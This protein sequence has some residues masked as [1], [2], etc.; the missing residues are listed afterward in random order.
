[1]LQKSSQST[2]G[3]H[4]EI[5]PGMSPKILSKSLFED[6]FRRIDRDFTEIFS[7]IFP[8]TIFGTRTGPWIY[9]RYDL[10]I[11]SEIFQSTPPDELSQFIPVAF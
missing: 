11:S 3:I 5:T 6:L 7:L 8:K 2:I 9:G 10:W 1:M 4:P